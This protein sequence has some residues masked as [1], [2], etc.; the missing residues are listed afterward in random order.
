[1]ALCGYGISEEVSRKL[2]KEEIQKPHGVLPWRH[3]EGF[4]LLALEQMGIE[5]AKPM[6]NTVF[7]D[8]GIPD[9]RAYL[10]CSN[11][12]VPDELSAKEKVCPYFHTVFW[13]APWPEIYEN[14][15][16]RPQSYEEAYLLGVEI[17]KVYEG[18]GYKILEVPNCS[19]KERAH[20]IE[21]NLMGTL[22]N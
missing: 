3:L 18:Q 21:K 6:S 7:F 1:L 5:W 14:D 22:L 9:I 10:N 8:R 12:S 16:E 17:K 15:P 2:I 4:A 19:P 13:C 20:F 11:I